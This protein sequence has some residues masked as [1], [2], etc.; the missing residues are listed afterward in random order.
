MDISDA[1]TTQEQSMCASYFNV[2][3]GAHGKE[4]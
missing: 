3:L 2:H 1:Y 4:D